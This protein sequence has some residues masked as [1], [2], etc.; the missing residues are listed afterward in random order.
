MS[1]KV[2]GTC[3][4][5]AHFTP[6]GSTGP[7]EGLSHE[8]LAKLRAIADA[9]APGPWHWSGNIDFEDPSLCRWGNYGLEEVVSSVTVDRTPDDPRIQNLEDVFDDQADIDQARQEFLEDENGDPRTDRHL[10]FTV[11]GIKTSARAMPVFEVCPS[12]TDR[13]DPRVYRANVTGIRHPDAVFIA[14]ADP[15]TVL[16]LL[17][18]VA[19]LRERVEELEQR[20]QRW[21]DEVCAYRNLAIFLGAKP[22]DMLN[23]YDRNL[24]ESGIDTGFAPDDSTTA[25]AR[26]EVTGLW[27]E[28]DA[29]RDRAERAEGERDELVW[30]MEHR[31]LSIHRG[32]FV[33]SDGTRTTMV[34]KVSEPAR[35]AKLLAAA[36]ENES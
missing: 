34:V 15:S 4:G 32:D 35:L 1:D 8:E 19:A 27:A 28:N 25:D 3:V 10:S 26:A 2:T 31:G 12:A 13:T 14:A 22:T 33:R 36:L 30:L 16:Q 18:A 21:V 23:E 20:D 5:G 11:G 24:C 17:G 7:G 6:A 29:L 9:A